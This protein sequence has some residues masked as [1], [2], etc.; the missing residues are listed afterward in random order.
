M[1]LTPNE[2]NAT[3]VVIKPDAVS[4]GLVGEI[5]SRFEKKGL[6]TVAKKSD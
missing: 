5:L 4:R 6:A 3:L 1:S 2:L